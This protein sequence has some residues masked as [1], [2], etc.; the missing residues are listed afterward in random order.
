MKPTLVHM[1][2]C[3]AS[4]SCD[5]QVEIALPLNILFTAKCS[6]VEF[7]HVTFGNDLAL[8]E[9]IQWHLQWVRALLYPGIT[10]HCVL[11]Y[12]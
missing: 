6:D 10:S 5:E 4:F 3:T 9:W 7:Y 12:V 8:L 1:R 11:A 2:F